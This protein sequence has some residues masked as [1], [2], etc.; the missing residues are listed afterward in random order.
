MELTFFELANP[1]QLIFQLPGDKEFFQHLNGSIFLQA[2][3]S[4]THLSHIALG[5]S[6]CDA[7]DGDTAALTKTLKKNLGFNDSDLH[8]DL[9]NTE[10]KRVTAHLKDGEKRLIYDNGRFTL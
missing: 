9:V 5:S 8:W 6:Y 1:K 10:Q 7:Y 3:E 4:I 2:P